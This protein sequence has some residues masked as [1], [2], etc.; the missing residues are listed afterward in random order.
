VAAVVSRREV[1]DLC[2]RRVGR[3]RRRAGEAPFRA[4][5]ERL[6]ELRNRAYDLVQRPSLAAR[7]REA[8]SSEKPPRLV[9]MAP[10]RLPALEQAV[11]DL[12]RHVSAY[13]QSAGRS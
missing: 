3:R 2:A 4:L 1:D 13:R 10:A 5:V 12:G 8:L 6:L 9:L 7:I 11:V